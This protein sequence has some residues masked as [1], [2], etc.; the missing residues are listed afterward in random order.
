M[1]RFEELIGDL[2]IFRALLDGFLA[3]WEGT[4]DVMLADPPPLYLF[5][6][7]KGWVDFCRKVRSASA[8]DRLC[9][10][11]DRERAKQAAEQRGPISYICHAGLLDIAVPIIVE[12]KLV[13]T[14]FCGQCRSWDDEE[15]EEGRRKAEETER[16]LGLDRGKLLAL[17]EKLRQASEEQVEDV[18][19]RLWQV[20][21]YWASKGFEMIEHERTKAELSD[22]LREG[23][24]IQKIVR[25]LSEIVELDRFW[26]KVDNALSY[27]CDL[28]GAG[29]GALLVCDWQNRTLIIKSIAG[30]ERG[31]FIDNIYSV[32]NLIGGVLKEKTP[33]VVSFDLLA[34][35]ESFCRDISSLGERRG[36]PEQVALIPFSLSGEH[37]G[38][39]MFCLR[40]EKDIEMSLSIDKE[41]DILV[42]AMPQIATAYE[43]CRL[44]TEQK[45]LAEER[46]QLVQDRDNFLEDVSHQ[47]IAPLSG[48]QADSD[49]LWRYFSKW[50]EERNANQIKAIRDISRWAA[51]L[52]RNFAWAVRTGGAVSPVLTRRWTSMKRFLIWRAIDVQGL[53]ATKGGRVWVDEE[54]VGEHSELWIDRTL[55]SQA[56]VNLLDNAVKYADDA[57]EVRISASLTDSEVRIHITDFGIPVKAEDIGKIFQRGYRSK[58]AIAKVPAGTGIG[59]SVAQDIVRLHEGRVFTTPSTYDRARKAHRTRFTITLPRSAYRRRSG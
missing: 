29:H 25:T 19:R 37:E 10:E 2:D 21:T 27:I 34:S 52:A 50:D 5:E 40:K 44:F 24:A 39:M 20:A 35:E 15:E 17:R 59:L 47:L 30:V 31:P 3:G 18:K 4:F 58:E 54:S 36:M 7:R 48:I 43:N 11:C 33:V 38:M 45:K 14:I 57:T 16:T 9:V 1:S 12:G 13:A 53:A 51:R 23:E 42:Q 55:F 41:L 26:V 56:V 28:I 8:G 32:G 49:R 22:R 6:P 46:K